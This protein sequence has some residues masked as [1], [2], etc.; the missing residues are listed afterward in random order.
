MKHSSIALLSLKTFFLGEI[1]TR[2]FC[3]YWWIGCPL[4]H[5]AKA[6]FKSLTFSTE[7]FKLRKSKIS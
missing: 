2:V 3:S 4:R 7:Q 6:R 1:Q 5:A